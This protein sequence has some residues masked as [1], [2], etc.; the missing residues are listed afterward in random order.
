VVREVAECFLDDFE[1]IVVDDASVDATSVIVEKLAETDDTI[2]LV[3]NQRNEGLGG[4]FRRGVENAKYSHCLMVPGDNAYPV[5]SLAAVIARIG[6]ADIITTYTSNPG[7]RPRHRRLLSAAFTRMMNALFG[8]HL[9]YYN[10]ISIFPSALLKTIPFGSS[11]AYS[12][13]IL[14]PMIRDEGLSVHEIPVPIQERLAGKSQ[15]LRPR[16][17]LA[18]CL[19][20]VRLRMKAFEP[21]TS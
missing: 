20:I 7:I 14:V 1:I 3:R 15:A 2:R 5:E 18:V 13:Q 11:F 19:A 12:A 8:L 4:A 16:Q 17:V 6:E 10:G 21:I 9:R